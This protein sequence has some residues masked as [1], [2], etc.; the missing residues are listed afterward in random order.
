MLE[1]KMEQH[2]TG[3]AKVSVGWTSYG[4]REAVRGEAEC[5]RPCVTEM[6][7]VT[8]SLREAQHS[9]AEDQYDH[10]C[11]LRCYNGTT[12][13]V[14]SVLVGPLLWIKDHSPC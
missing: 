10:V 11:P 9:L 8:G 5:G 12:A 14:Q 3:C 7:R 4:V 1:S 2:H 13:L 6:C